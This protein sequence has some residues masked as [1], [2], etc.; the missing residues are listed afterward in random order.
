M[1]LVLPPVLF[2]S[3]GFYFVPNVSASSPVCVF[4]CPV[5]FFLLRYRPVSDV[6]LTPQNGATWIEG[7]SQGST[8]MTNSPQFHALGGSPSLLRQWRTPSSG[9]QC[10]QGWCPLNK[11][12]SAHS[13]GPWLGFRSVVPRRQQLR[14]WTRTI[15]ASSSCAVSGVRL[16]CRPPSAGVASHLTP[17]APRARH[18][19]SSDVEGIRWRAVPRASAEKLERDVHQNQGPGPRPLARRPVGWPPGSGRWWFASLHRSPLGHRHDLGQCSQSRWSPTETVCH[20]LRG[21]SRPGRP[22]ALGRPCLRDGSAATLLVQTL[23]HSFVMFVLRRRSPCDCWSAVAVWELM[24]RCQRPPMLSGAT[25]SFEH[26][27]RTHAMS[28]PDERQDTDN[29][30]PWTKTSC[31]KNFPAKFRKFLTFPASQAAGYHE[32]Q[33]LVQRGKHAPS[34]Y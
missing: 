23:V 16:F 28:A 20:P 19:G 29:A 7:S 24:A 5:A 30:C 33:G 15:F 32:R 27:S 18:Q 13:K 6:D 9:V 3:R 11:R 17:V 34:C 2:L 10:G 4:F 25:G 1:F 12:L 31:K 21:C 14:A 8:R 22:R 26:A